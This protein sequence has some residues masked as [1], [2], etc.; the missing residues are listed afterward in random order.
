MVIYFQG[1]GLSFDMNIC[2]L[3]RHSRLEDVILIKTE[4][5]NIQSNRWTLNIRP[6]LS[7][8]KSITMTI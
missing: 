7:V 3:I 5:N 4:K 6:F 2:M 1:N 8:T